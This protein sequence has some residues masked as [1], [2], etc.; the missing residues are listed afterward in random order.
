MAVARLIP[1][2]KATHMLIHVRKKLLSS[3]PKRGDLSMTRLIIRSNGSMLQYC[4]MSCG[5]SAK[6][7]SDCD[8]AGSP[9]NIFRYDFLI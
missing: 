7:Q 9:R 2:A 8:I 4:P 1:P 3:D 5:L 6:G